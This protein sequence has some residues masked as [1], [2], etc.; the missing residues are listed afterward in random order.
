MSE[1][2][3]NAA[4]GAGAAAG[5][6]DSGQ[7][8]GAQAQQQQQAAAGENT[9]QA[10]EMPSVLNTTEGE[11]GDDNLSF[12]DFVRKQFPDEKFEDDDGLLKHAKKHMKGLLEYQKTNRERNKKVTQML[13]SHPEL[14][15]ILQDLDAGADMRVAIARHF[16]PANLS[17]DDNE[18]D[19]DAWKKAAEDRQKKFTERQQWQDTYAKNR[20]ESGEIF[21]QFAVDTKMDQPKAQEFAEKVDGILTDV[22]NGKLSRQFLDAMHKALMFDQ[23]V[24]QAKE[25]G[26]VAGRN[27][28][29][30]AKIAKEEAPKGDGLPDLK[31]SGEINE[32]ELPE[33]IKMMAGLVDDFNAKRQRF[34]T[35]N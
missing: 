33:G 7:A 19:Y 31:K 9:T 21:K 17:V 3:G 8:Q 11:D 22:Y 27:E 25:I 26:K 23:A 4:A 28:Q 30:A 5:Q 16:D 2:A 13:H 12:H 6:G 15:A 32:A 18:P 29:I 35:K 24:E 20:K 14:V 10:A 1:S 34:K